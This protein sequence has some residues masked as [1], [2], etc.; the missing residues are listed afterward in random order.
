MSETNKG[1]S[2]RWELT[3]TAGLDVEVTLW[4]NSRQAKTKPD[5][6][7]G[8]REKSGDGREVSRDK[9]RHPFDWRTPGLTLTDN[10]DDF[11]KPKWKRNYQ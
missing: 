8:D 10:F 4:Q 7:C 1:L 3:P 2:K 6:P 5:H 11:V 9:I